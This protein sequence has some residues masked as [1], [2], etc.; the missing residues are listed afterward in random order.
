MPARASTRCVSALAAAALAWAG[1]PPAEAQF[2]GRNKVQYEA[3]TPRVLRTA[4]FDIHH[5]ARDDATARLVGRMAERWHARLSGIFEH[6]LSDRQVVILYG[7][8]SAFAHTNVVSP[9]LDESIGGVT[10]PAR[11]RIAMPLA[12][13]LAETD[14]VLGHEIVHAF[15]F[16][17]ASR[18]GLGRNTPGWFS[19]G[20]AEYVS[21]GSTDPLTSR[22]VLDSACS[23]R[24]PSLRQLGKA[25]L[26]PYRIGQA[27]WAHL[28]HRH[29][30]DI[31]RRMLSS[32]PRSDVIARLEAIT[33]QSS[34]E[35]SAG[36]HAAERAR[37]GAAAA[38]GSDGSKRIQHRGRMAIAPAISPDGRRIV[39]VAERDRISVDLLVADTATG[40]IERRLLS[41]A[42]TPA[43]ES[44]QYVHS[45]ASWNPDGSQVVAAVV[46][47][48]TPALLF[49]D[50]N[51]GRVSRRI[52]LD[53]FAQVV[54]PAWSP[55]GRTIAFTGILSGI[56]DL[57]TCDLASGSIRRLTD[58]AFTD[59]QPAWSPDGRR[60][61]WSTDRHTTNLA[62]LAFGP[63]QV[64]V[65]DLDSGRVSRVPQHTDATTTSP[66]WLPDGGLMAV[67]ARTAG[68]AATLLDESAAAAHV[69]DSRIPAVAGLTS[70]SPMLS[71]AP[72]AGVAAWST[73]VDGRFE[74]RVRD[75]PPLEARAHEAA[76]ARHAST[77]GAGV[78]P[79]AT[80]GSAVDR[81]LADPDTGLPDAS[82]F[83]SEPYAS[84]IGFNTVAQPYLAAGGSRIGS[85]VRGGATMLFGDVTGDRVAGVSLQVGSRMLDVGAEARWLDRRSRWY[86]G[87]T[88]SYLP[89]GRLRTDRDLLQADGDRQVRATSELTVQRQSALGAFVAW[90]F[91][92]ARRVEFGA[93][94]RHIDV[95]V[96]RRSVLF[97]E[98]G[99]LL[100]DTRV[101]LP[102]G[103]GA[104]LGETRVAFVHDSTIFGGTGP[105]AGARWRVE[106]ATHAGTL[107]FGSVT[108]DARKYFAPVRPLTI[109]VRLAHSGRYGRDAADPRL[110]PLYVGSRLP[111]R[112]YG[113]RTLTERCAAS[114]DAGCLAGDDLFG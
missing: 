69:V 39:F 47:K 44:L 100:A 14:H 24:L 16:D 27:L 8:P 97:G 91:S 41:R 26:S 49:V 107:A 70:T 78:A 2:F 1:A 99:R 109:A 56:S 38:E 86:W 72:A 79:V 92:R 19:E 114:E 12:A 111:V 67:V 22:W 105:V 15:Q 11:R 21:V 113:S 33:G 101:D 60:I 54:T 68:P 48:G 103:P 9:L 37:C 28:V 4:H 76:G 52:R 32:K 43:L 13:T 85:F 59:L 34:E 18:H 29:G 45:A 96:E 108:I 50:V 30:S 88:A 63:L 87:V 83:R 5:D 61:A 64:S 93:A 73:L 84:R 66:Q 89:Y 77:A 55:D 23:D 57:Y 112:G 42:A 40:A 98:G 10:E 106:A 20:L 3:K 58:D 75:L 6:T 94:V 102:R 36:W 90:P 51:R 110:L 25:R 46:E 31:L 65:M 17:M 35:I 53:R 82:S 80:A 74:I 81:F 95:G 62:L 71:V 7:Q 104:V